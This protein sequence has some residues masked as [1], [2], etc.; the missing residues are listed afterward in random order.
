[1]RNSLPDLFDAQPD[2]LFQ[3]VT[4]LN[5]SVLQGNGVPV[6]SVLQVWYCFILVCMLEYLNSKE[7]GVSMRSVLLSSNCSTKSLPPFQLP[8]N[9]L[10]NVFLKE[11][12]F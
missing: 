11:P 12:I 4:M 1:M 7:N 8:I 2:L 3:L 10:Y 6:Y 9:L 5:P